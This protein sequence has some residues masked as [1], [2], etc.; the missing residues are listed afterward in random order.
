MTEF[1]MT[2]GLIR[3]ARALEHQVFALQVGEKRSYFEVPPDNQLCYAVMLGPAPAFPGEQA[4]STPQNV[5]LCAALHMGK[6]PNTPHQWRWLQLAPEAYGVMSDDLV[7]GQAA[8]G[9]WYYMV[10]S[11]GAGFRALDDADNLVGPA[12]FYF[13]KR[14]SRPLKWWEPLMRWLVRKSGGA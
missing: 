8:P 11:Q 6:Q 5:L 4:A 12:E 1:K 10:L 13:V 2:E 14:S 9:R 7:R 3:Q